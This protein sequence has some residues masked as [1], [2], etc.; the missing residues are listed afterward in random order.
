MWSQNA[1]CIINNGYS[2][3]THRIILLPYMHSNIAQIA[4]M[5]VA[6]TIITGVI[7]LP[8]LEAPTTMLEIPISTIHSSEASDLI[9]WQSQNNLTTN[10]EVST[11]LTTGNSPHPLCTTYKCTDGNQVLRPSIRRNRLKTLGDFLR[12]NIKRPLKN[13]HSTATTEK[14]KHSKRIPLAKIKRPINNILTG[15][16]PSLSGYRKN[17]HLF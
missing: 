3:R 4:R 15:T 13:R 10:K 7:Q 12:P 16:T 8:I 6:K 17:N 5:W 14:T 9:C 2:P 1:T 11:T